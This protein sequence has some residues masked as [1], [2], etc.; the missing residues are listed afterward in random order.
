MVPVL[1]AHAHTLGTVRHIPV[2]AKTPWKTF[3]DKGSSIHSEQTNRFIDLS[4]RKS[5]HGKHATH[6]LLAT[7]I[8]SPKKVRLCC[9][10]SFCQSTNTCT[11]RDSLQTVELR[12]PNSC[13]RQFGLYCWFSFSNPQ[14]DVTSLLSSG[15]NFH[16]DCWVYSR[17]F[18][19]HR[20][21]RSRVVVSA[22][23]KIVECSNPME[24]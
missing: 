12:H 10:I 23:P 24:T 22:F 19:L 11:P 18:H 15:S 16:F 17:H 9:E 2:W 20:Q 4:F 6:N 21:L 14:N 13:T 7:W 5:T 8:G 3:L 1:W